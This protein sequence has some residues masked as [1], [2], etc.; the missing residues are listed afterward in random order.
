MADLEDSATL[1][2]VGLNVH[3]NSPGGLFATVEANWYMQDLDDDPR[4]LSPGSEPRSDDQT[5]QI[6]ALVGCRFNDNRCEISAGILNVLNNDYRFSPLSPYGNIARERTTVLRCR[7][8][9]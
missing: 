3:W 9:F 2:E 5:L 4:G 8:S 1:H 7:I 6:N